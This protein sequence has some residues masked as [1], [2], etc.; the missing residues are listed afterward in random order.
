M[1]VGTSLSYRHGLPPATITPMPMPSR[2]ACVATVAAVLASPLTLNAQ[3]ADRP[4]FAEIRVPKPPTLASGRDGNVL[5]Y[6]V[7]VTNFARTPITWTL[8]EVLDATTGVPLATVRDSS[9]QRDL[10]RPGVGAVPIAQRATIAGGLRAVLFVQ[11]PVPFGLRPTLL[12]HVLTFTDSVG[13]RTVT[14]TP[15]P[16]TLDVAVIGPPFKGGP[17]LAANGPSNSSG[18]RRSLIPLNGEMAIAQRFAIDWVLVDSTFNTH[19]GDSLDN[20]K[21]YAQDVD[22]IAVADGIITATKDGIP[23]NIPG[24]QSRAVPITLETV[25]GNHVILDIGSGR[26]AFYAHVR[27][28]S[29]RVKVGDKVKK[30]QVL[31]KLGNSGNSSEPHLHFHLSD[32]PSPLGSQGI[33]YVFETLEFVGKCAGVIS[34]CAFSRSDVRKRIMPFE[35]DLVQFPK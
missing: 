22:V 32:A 17:W 6:E 26:Y 1:A 28:G 2:L 24:E 13:T 21:Y 3:L 9:L 5:T 30:G 33:P 8:L 23:E 20:S 35:N 11:L 29:I 12:T 18:H 16:V 14:A 25:G 7:H 27:P 34:G 15:V 31:A 10:S 4:V 19:Q